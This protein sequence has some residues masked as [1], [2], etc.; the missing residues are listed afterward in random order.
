MFSIGLCMVL[1]VHV[2]IVKAAVSARAEKQLLL[3]RLHPLMIVQPMARTKRG[4]GFWP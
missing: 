3:G 4:L 1:G 2:G